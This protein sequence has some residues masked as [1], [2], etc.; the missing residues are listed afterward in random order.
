[1]TAFPTYPDGEPLYAAL[2]PPESARDFA[3]TLSLSD[4][5]AAVLDAAAGRR[6]L[7]VRLGGL[8]VRDGLLV[9]G[10]ER[11]RL[12]PRSVKQLHHRVR[13]VLGRRVERG[14][15]LRRGLALL[16]DRIVLLRVG[17]DE[18]RAVLGGHFTP[19]DDGDVLARIARAATAMDWCDLRVRFVA[20]SDAITIVRATLGRSRVDLRTDDPFEAGVELQSSDVGRAALTLRAVTWRNV[21]FNWTRHR[22][23]T[24]RLVHVG[25]AH[26]LDRDWRLV[27]A[28]VIRTS[29]EMLD[30]W[31]SCP[32][33]DAA[34]DT[35][36]AAK[37]RSLAGRLAHERL[38]QRIV[39]DA[40]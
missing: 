36:E 7:R 11:L 22:A 21:C 16:R 2:T 4:A 28:E 26:R 3:P 1:M 19:M 18:V 17:G 6:D 40:R 30:G 37:A 5:A 31:N 24:L 20:T 27:L 29:R 38:A 23:P 10:G 33:F 9:V 15:D 39:E 25:G 14:H 13:L 12:R 8:V 32:A 34:N 35:S